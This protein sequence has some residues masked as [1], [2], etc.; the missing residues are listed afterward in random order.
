MIKIFFRTEKTLNIPNTR[1]V[2]FVKDLMFKLKRV[3]AGTSNK[4][5]DDC[6]WEI[7]DW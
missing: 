6:T 7:N 2:G 3:S 1:S 5:P 4:D